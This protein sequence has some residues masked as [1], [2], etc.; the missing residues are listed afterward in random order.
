VD[1]DEVGLDR[2]TVADG[3]LGDGV[4]DLLEHG[5]PLG[6]VLGSFARDTM[7]PSGMTGGTPL[8]KCAAISP[9]T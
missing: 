8:Q 9:E 7:R 4:Q 5:V 1:L 6:E 2:A 3:R